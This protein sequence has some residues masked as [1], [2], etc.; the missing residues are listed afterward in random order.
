MKLNR[1]PDLIEYIPNSD[2]DV[3]H[4]YVPMQTFIF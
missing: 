1:K 3:Q 2:I 4:T